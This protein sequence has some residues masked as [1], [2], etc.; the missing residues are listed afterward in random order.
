MA[1]LD[2][3]KGS[4]KPEGVRAFMGWDGV[5][6]SDDGIDG[7]DMLRA[8]MARAASESCGQCFPCRN[9][10]KKISA[11]LE[12]LCQGEDYPKAAGRLEELARMVAG[13]ARCDLG[14]TAPQPLLDILATKPELIK[15]RRTEAGNYV[16][17]VTAPCVNAC[18]SHVNIPDYLEKIRYRQFGQALD[19]VMGD[20]PLPG[21]I[22]RVCVRPC[23][24]ACKRGLVDAP[25]AIKHLKRFL[26]DEDIA[27]RPRLTHKKA[28]LGTKKVAVVGAGPAGLSCAYYLAK[29]GFGVT[30]F[31]AQEAP[32]GM[33][34]YGIP[35]YRLPAPIMAREAEVVEAEGVEIKYGVSIGR[36]LTLKDL[37]SRGFEAVF[38]AP[39]APGFSKMKAEGEDEGYEGFIAGVRFLAEAARGRKVVSGERVAVI[40]GGNVA[41]DCVRTALRQGF[42]DVQLLYRRTLKE[43]PADHQEIEEAQEEGVV[44]NY[45]VAPVKILAENHKVTGL[46]CQ[47][48]ELGEPDASGR[49]SPVPVKD[50]EFVLPCDVVIPAIGQA[51]EV[52]LVL[53]GAGGGLDKWKN[54]AADAIT[55]QVDGLEG[56]FGGGDCATGPSTLIAAL[57]A[58]KRAAA[59]LADHLEGRAEGAT[60]QEKLELLIGKIGVLDQAKAKPYQ[61]FTKK[62]PMPIMDPHERIK[63]FKEVET[64]VKAPEAVREAERCLRCFRVALAAF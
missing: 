18:P 51:V 56:I 44:F 41:M 22:G 10:L 35:D 48:M 53:K 55:G 3:W 62:M 1:V 40:G 28:P 50:G 54:L 45:L 58:G 4:G 47:K 27:K 33:A 31:E 19:R 15:A 29:R 13:S 37:E 43:M 8:Y 64:G 5:W 17:A 61:G 25:L 24:S 32:G 9:G 34:K 12:R 60:G 21:T 42:K 46:L 30:I 14:Q 16:G 39:G 59:H 36:D 49:R 38:L 11:I 57:A 2:T 6:I 20:C 63:S 23:E 7:L 52:E 26:A